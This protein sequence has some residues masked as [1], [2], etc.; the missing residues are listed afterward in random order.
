MVDEAKE[1]S[2]QM[3]IGHMARAIMGEAQTHKQDAKMMALKDGQVVRGVVLQLLD[4]QD[5][6]ISVNGARIRAHLET[7]LQ[8]G[9]AAWLQ[10]Q[11]QSEDGMLILRAL[12]LSNS[13]SSEELVVKLLQQLGLKDGPV[14]REII[15]QAHDLGVQLSAKDGRSLSMFLTNADRP[16]NMDASRWTQ[17]AII[18]QQRG[19]PLTTQTVQSIGTVLHGKPLPEQLM[20]VRAQLTQHLASGDAQTAQLSQAARSIVSKLSDTI[21]LWLT[22]A[23][24]ERMI[25]QESHQTGQRSGAMMPDGSGQT[26]ML[27]S[28]QGVQPESHIQG[29]ANRASM[30]QE[31]VP[32]NPTSAVTSSVPRG[33]EQGGGAGSST[34]TTT[35]ATNSSALRDL[36]V[37][38][39]GASPAGSASDAGSTVR[40]LG[41]TA[42]TQAAMPGQLGG[43]DIRSHMTDP[44]GR[45]ASAHQV[46]HSHTFTAQP[47]DGS[48]L[49]QLLQALG[50]GYEHDLME[51]FVLQQQPMGREA[52]SPHAA[53]MLGQQPELGDLPTTQSGMP[54]A[55]AESI[56][57]LLLQAAGLE[58]LP[59]ALRE[60]IQQV[61][62]TITGQQLLLTADRAAPLN[63][64]TLFVPFYNEKGE[65][66]ASVHVQTRKGKCGLLDSDNCNLLFDLQLSTLGELMIDVQVTERIVALRIFNEH[67]LMHELVEEGKPHIKQAI[68]ELGYRL[69]HMKTL[70]L[71]EPPSSPLTSKA[72]EPQTQLR[73]Y[74]SGSTYKGVDLRI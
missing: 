15:R 1:G 12:T 66:M 2:Q 11:P 45:S 9:Q 61:A 67:P 53:A 17:S 37:P 34:G 52:S 16:A 33:N 29:Q 51:R 62:Q 23:S 24:A 49:K 27:S 28:R 39:G 69:S 5:A 46:S 44:E 3:N 20:D 48:M 6:F 72:E 57:S 68:E 4:G 70:P 26:A 73:R 60:S 65:Q 63:Y 32:T 71:P 10:V 14:N 74:A 58:Q 47:V 21:G 8:I 54:Q 35:A 13:Q 42:L 30:I 56:K 64:V 19:L 36:S 38:P 55:S 59:A 7:P 25:A 31:P 18:T 43:Q 40:G 41:G 50:F 22:D